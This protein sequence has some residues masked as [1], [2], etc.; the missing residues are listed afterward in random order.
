V[1]KKVSKAGSAFGLQTETYA[2]RNAQAKG[3]SGVILR[4]NDRQ[5]IRER[6][7]L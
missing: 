1:F 5:A 3:G 7:L 4:N 6:S 2:I